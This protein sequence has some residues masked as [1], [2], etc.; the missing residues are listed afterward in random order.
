MKTD[1]LIIGCGIAG[2]AAAL[3]LSDNP[4]HHI[5]IL[6]RALQPEDSNTGWAQGGIVTHGLGD[7]PEKLVSDI[8]QAGGGIGSRKAARILATEGPRLVQSVLVERCGVRF[9]AQPNGEPVF[10]LEAAH[11]V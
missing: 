2:A 3:R 10:G 5:T 7:S 6:T 1:T 11:S 9:D 8:M 4:N